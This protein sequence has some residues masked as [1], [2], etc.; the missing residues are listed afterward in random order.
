MREVFYTPPGADFLQA[1]QQFL[2]NSGRD[3][4][5]STIVFPGK[6]PSLYFKKQLSMNTT[7]AFYPPRLLSIEEFIDTIA[8]QYYPDFADIEAID[9][10]WLLYRTMDTLSTPLA[11]RLCG[12]GFGDFFP[13]GLHLFDFMENLDREAIDNEQLKGLEKNA[14]LGFDVPESTNALLAHIV[15]LREA[16]HRV[17]TEKRLMTRGFK[18][19]C[20]LGAFD[21]T[22]PEGSGQV[23]FAGLFALAA[24]ERQI[25]KTIWQNGSGQI[26]LEGNPWEWPILTEFVHFLGADATPLPCPVQQAQRITLHSA[27]DTH[28]EVISTLKILSD[29]PDSRTAVVLPSPETL[30]PLLSFAVDGVDNPYN[31]SLGYPLSRTSV[32]DLLLHTLN[33]QIQKRPGENIPVAEYFSVVSHPFVK[34]LITPL[35]NSEDH[36]D[37]TDDTRTLRNAI[38]FLEQAF[39]KDSTEENLAGR[40][41]ITPAEVDN[42]LI[43][44]PC[45]MQVQQ[46]NNIFF[47]AFENAVTIHDISECLGDLLEFVLHHTTVRAFVLSQEIFRAA[48]EALERLKGMMSSGQPFHR[49]PEENHRAICTFVAAYLETVKIP[50]ET[51]PIE[52]LEIIGFLETRNITFQNVVILDLNEGVLPRSRMVNP[53]V[54]L[55]I[56][57]IL[58]IPSPA[59]HEEI[60]RYYFYRLVRSARNV[61]LLYI[62]SDEKVRSRYIERIIWEEEKRSGRMNAIQVKRRINRINVRTSSHTPSIPKT[63]SIMA[64]LLETTFSPSALDDYIVCPVLFYYRRVLYFRD[65]RITE[66]GLDASKRGILIHRILS[67]TFGNYVGRAI[68]SSVFNELLADME[69]IVEEVLGKPGL[70]GEYY[71]FKTLT[72]YKLA[73]F[74]KRTIHE[75]RGPFI[76]QSVEKTFKHAI[77]TGEHTIRM[78]GI[79]DRIDYL[80][81][82][83]QHLIIDYKTGGGKQYPR[84]I[85]KRCSF[86]NASDIHNYVRSLQLPL[87]LRLFTENV[88]LPLSKAGAKLMLLR[89]NDEEDLFAGLDC[90]KREDLFS[91]Y[92]KGFDTLMGDLLNSD[93]PFVPFDT[94]ACSS[95]LFN[96]L[97]HV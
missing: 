44:D 12:K 41:F 30:F 93:L 19:L 5:S 63:P 39:S 76:V 15:S 48:L 60:F 79:I 66:E 58:Q 54:P 52:N 35:G 92:M 86:E 25:I 89:S 17:L 34:N 47:K 62:D 71:L 59:Y 20:C 78:Q 7:G 81:E 32:F 9:A 2:L 82:T 28:G 13:W 23:C 50:F 8:A 46:I 88:N 94:D 68:D 61:H 56:Y 37:E 57:D 43:N 96:D 49:E 4:A 6:R 40:P 77:K 84:S 16:F 1:L 83:D 21:G 36:G 70:S 24:T 45:R 51:K 85:L 95:C 67:R 55:G 75:A 3:L 38:S 22:L 64:H 53:L 18:H 97:C 42:L 73:S 90:E 69:T 14:E 11:Q 31:V 29:M 87:Y 27:I 74:L 26:I 65:E 80:P 33:A 10:V 72:T 91:L